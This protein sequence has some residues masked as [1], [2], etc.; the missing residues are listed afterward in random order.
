LLESTFKL[1]KPEFSTLF[2]TVIWKPGCLKLKVNFE[3]VK[4][5][6]KTLTLVIFSYIF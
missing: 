3:I 4:K 5:S 1:M 2:Y 6:L